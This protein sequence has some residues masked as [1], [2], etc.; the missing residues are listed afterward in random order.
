MD[1]PPSPPI[2]LALSRAAKIVGRAFDECLSAA[3]GSLPTWLI[4][5]SLKT[6]RLGNQRE[7]AAAVG[8]EG[9]TLTHHLNAMETKG[10][11][12]RRRDPAN[13][14][15]H[16][17]ELTDEGERLFHR[18]RAA[19]QAHDERLRTGLTPADLTTLT[20]VLTQMTH[21]VAADDGGPDA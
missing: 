13:R 5:I 19:A 9:A 14:R 17:V 11:V 3:G 12:T 1:S 7:L 16:V 15:I 18:L 10:L 6:H 2:G 20:H 21:N 4:M 8:I